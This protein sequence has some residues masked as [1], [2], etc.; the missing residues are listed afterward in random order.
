M[1]I[2]KLKMDKT[3]KKRLIWLHQRSSMKV[4]SNGKTLL[5]YLVSLLE[6][7]EYSFTFCSHSC[8]LFSN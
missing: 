3:R 8:A 4:E 5:T 6:D 1:R 2:L 7:L